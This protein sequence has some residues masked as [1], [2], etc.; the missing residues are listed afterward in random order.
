MK[1]KHRQT[2]STSHPTT[3]PAAS[4]LW[5]GAENEAN[6]RCRILLELSVWREPGFVE[7]DDVLRVDRLGVCVGKQH[8][9]SG[10]L[11]VPRVDHGNLL[12][13]HADTVIH[14]SERG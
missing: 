4:N 1:A 13:V 7:V 5:L 10:L 9:G 11:V 14:Q 3:A 2:F 6:R 8:I 12:V